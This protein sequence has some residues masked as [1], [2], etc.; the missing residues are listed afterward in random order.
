MRLAT[1][2]RH[3][4]CL[5]I[6]LQMNVV[7]LGLML[8]GVVDEDSVNIVRFVCTMLLWYVHSVVCDTSH[9]RDILLTLPHLDCL[10]ICRQMSPVHLGLMLVGVVHEDSVKIV[11]LFV[12]WC[13]YG[14]LNTSFALS[15]SHER[16]GLLT[17]CHFD[18]FSFG[19]QMNAIQ[20]GLMLMGVVDDDSVKIDP[21]RFDARYAMQQSTNEEHRQYI[22]GRS[23]TGGA[24]SFSGAFH[25][26][27]S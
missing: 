19:P 6:G 4:D 18:C 11:R 25:F 10:S 9:E 1:H 2:L 20:V 7:H 24:G 3:L 8:A 16:N 23:H 17:L 5:A 14:K 12:P 21:R 26:I 22:S 15:P 27:H 13:S